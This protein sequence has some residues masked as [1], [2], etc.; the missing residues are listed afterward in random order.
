[1][2]KGFDFLEKILEDQLT[3]S[4]D[5]D[6]FQVAGFPLRYFTFED[7][8]FTLFQLGKPIYSPGGTFWVTTPG[9]FDAVTGS[10]IPGASYSY[11]ENA[12]VGISRGDDCSCFAIP[13]K[14]PLNE[15]KIL[16]IFSK[17]D[18][19]LVYFKARTTERS[20]LWDTLEL[21]V[22]EPLKAVKSG[23]GRIEEH[24]LLGPEVPSHLEKI[25]SPQ[26]MAVGGKYFLEAVNS[27]VP[28]EFPLLL[29]TNNS[30]KLFDDLA[31]KPDVQQFGISPESA[32]R[33]SNWLQALNLYRDG[34]DF[35]KGNK[36]PAFWGFDSPQLIRSKQIEKAQSLAEKSNELDGQWSGLQSLFENIEL[37]KEK[38]A[39]PDSTSEASVRV[40]SLFIGMES[41]AFGELNGSSFF[42][43]IY[44]PSLGVEFQMTRR[45]S[46]GTRLL[47]YGTGPAFMESF[48]PK[49]ISAHLSFQSPLRVNFANRG[50]LVETSIFYQNWDE[51]YGAS[52]KYYGTGNCYG[53]SVGFTQRNS[54]NPQKFGTKKYRLKT[55]YSF[56]DDIFFSDDTGRLLSGDGYSPEGFNFAFE[57]GY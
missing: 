15:K 39:L 38:L 13:G 50:F 33:I 55:G 5:M 37:A 4:A 24:S 25:W 23:S 8:D 53:V 18:P 2:A 35:L 16:L 27:P 10:Y 1:M 42:D 43:A 17:H 28:Q 31:S 30:L 21:P 52:Q 6:T 32:L 41:R 57:I 9:R 48:S 22:L 56:G 51:V 46:L 49:R 54:Y 40:F 47:P 34:W 7:E 20:A 29:D 44:G 19:F 45:F 26:F 36:T 11:T 12:S 3:F 14:F